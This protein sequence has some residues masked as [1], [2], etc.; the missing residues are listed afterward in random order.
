VVT[1]RA[2]ASG[3]D[4]NVMKPLI[5]V[6]IFRFLVLRGVIFLVSC[7]AQMIARAAEEEEANMFFLFVTSDDIQN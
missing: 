4:R 3:S 6:D 5:F 2:G 1:D 7:G